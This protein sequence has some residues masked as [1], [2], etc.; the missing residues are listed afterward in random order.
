LIVR[1]EGR[2]YSSCRGEVT[3]R[4]TPA[5]VKEEDPFQNTETYR[6]NKNMVIGPDETGNEN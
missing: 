5:L 4:Q 2:I 3:R 1:A 6:K